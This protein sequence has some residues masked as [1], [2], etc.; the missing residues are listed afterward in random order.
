MSGTKAGIECFV[1][2]HFGWGILMEASSPDGRVLIHL[3][4]FEGWSSSRPPTLTTYAPE[5]ILKQSFCA[6][7]SCIQTARGKGV[8][9][10]Y[11]RAEDV[12]TVSLI[13]S[14]PTNGGYIDAGVSN[15]VANLARD[16]LEQ[17]IPS[18][19]GCSEEYVKALPVI[20]AIFAVLPDLESGILN[21]HPFEFFVTNL[22][23]VMG[24]NDFFPGISD[25]S[26]DNE[27][28]SSI[29]EISEKI[30][31]F[32]V[33]SWIEEGNI[34]ISGLQGEGFPESKVGAF[35][36]YWGDLSDAFGSIQDDV[37]LLIGTIS[38]RDMGQLDVD[39]FI[40]KIYEH[41]GT[42]RKL[43][44]DNSGIAEEISEEVTKITAKISKSIVD[45]I[46]SL[47]VLIDDR[48][49]ATQV[50]E[51][52]AQSKFIQ[53]LL[54]GK[55]RLQQRTVELFPELPPIPSIDTGSMYINSLDDAERFLER[56]V[57]YS[58]TIKPLL[59]VSSGAPKVAEIGSSQ[60]AFF[61][62]SAD[63]SRLL[64]LTDTRPGESVDG[65]ANDNNGGDIDS[66]DGL[67]VGGDASMEVVLAPASGLA[68]IFSNTAFA[69]T[70]DKFEVADFK[71][72][73]RKVAVGIA[74]SNPNIS[75]YELRKVLLNG[76]SGFMLLMTYM[77]Q[78]STST[79]LLA[80]NP[81]VA[82][83]EQAI[84]APVKAMIDSVSS[85]RTDKNTE[86]N[87][88]E[89]TGNGEPFPSIGLELQ[90]VDDM[91]RALESW[92]DL[93]D[94]LIM[95]GD[96][97]LDNLEEI[98]KMDEVEYALA[99]MRSMEIDLVGSTKTLTRESGIGE[100]EDDFDLMTV[101]GTV[102]N[103]VEARNRV[104]EKL[105]DRVLD[106]LLSYIPTIN[107]NS[108]DGLYE[109]IAY[110]ISSLDLSGFKF[111]KESVL[112]DINSNPL[113]NGGSLL[114]FKASNIEASFKGV[115]WKYEQQSFPNL[116][117]EGLL[118][119]VMESASLSLGFKMARVPK[120]TTAIL[121]GGSGI[122]YYEAKKIMIKYPVLSEQVEALR[123]LEEDAE[124][125]EVD[126]SSTSSPP[127]MPLSPPPVSYLGRPDVED[128]TGGFLL[129]PAPP[130]ED[131]DRGRDADDAKKA[132]EERAR[133]EN[134]WGEEV[135]EW[136]PVLLINE[137]DITIVN[138][139]TAVEQDGYSWIY[140]F[141]VGL[142]KGVLKD[143]IAKALV[144]L[145]G[146]N[147]AYLLLPVNN[148]VTTHW[149]TI[150]QY[151]F[152][153]FATTGLPVC[154]CTDFMSL[155]GPEPD[156]ANLAQIS[157][158]REWNLKMIPDGPMGLKLDVLS[159]QQDGTSVFQV[160]GIT[161][162]S[163]A[164]DA[165]KALK[166]EPE[167]F[168]DSQLACVNGLRTKGCSRERVQ[169]LLKAPRPLY[170]QLRLADGAYSA[171]KERQQKEA[172]LKAIKA[173]PLSTKEVEFEDG[174]LGLNLVELKR[175]GIVIIK[176]CTK[177]ADGSS[178]QAER[179]GLEPGMIM[180]SI[181]KNIIFHRMNLDQMLGLVKST[182]RPFS[183]MF[184][185]S[186]DF[187]FVISLQDA[188]KVVLIEH[189]GSVL[190]ESDAMGGKMCAPYDCALLQLNKAPI[191]SIKH[192]REMIV[193]LRATEPHT[194][195]RLGLRNHLA[196]SALEHLRNR[197]QSEIGA[198]KPLA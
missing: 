168:L 163:L 95:G 125:G 135:E 76:Q 197:I 55:D 7:G 157:P 21:Q 9:V 66:D 70:F 156:L 186:P 104:V 147:S 29:K 49:Q 154:T 124:G 34:L 45:S 187:N 46:N 11:R 148:L 62:E 170:L 61:D 181:D 150:K 107:I 174:A 57:E 195:V 162:G 90:T 177:A 39:D 172:N 129:P 176:A 126:R 23:Q 173:S 178:Q 171:I 14:G 143:K 123:L 88:G 193:T 50:Y 74:S 91:M 82:A 110:H 134:P 53:K 109:N 22:M 136:E 87:T 120:G 1:L 12:Y 8:L 78:I 89:R 146:Y 151:L 6:I 40:R 138:F 59:K 196:N 190:V 133:Q 119:A 10:D 161:P 41:L 51:K 139:D 105:K 142:F 198:K 73:I 77:Y 160:A 121:S 72:M 103:D 85:L 80:D 106:F 58:E 191:M 189:D 131:S 26:D 94:Q 56:I 2:T 79:E 141:L 166:F 44:S 108:L 81:I 32:N 63:N 122:S 31:N 13:H 5:T 194:P 145:I 18:I 19:D 117:G 71:A 27:R 184:A 116:Q 165:I 65:G 130:G 47:K 127:P 75:A 188:K 28:S 30:V 15:I 114:K 69:A 67:D 132:E 111:E 92:E 43:F 35:Q 159:N 101:A 24:T 25:S 102:I 42:A 99:H 84:P 115:E 60:A 180:L 140:N 97:L 179:L 167:L 38:T 17:V 137:L 16:E 149:D 112:L 113:E 128:V 4:D 83:I 98:K 37:N 3:E 33:D 48:F 93:A 52:F 185:R 36:K 54:S 100:N 158:S 164:E 68:S 96:N 192:F 86:A 155:V 182:P 183:A 64:S 118:N 152:T 144:D 153:D 20:E 169:E 175:A